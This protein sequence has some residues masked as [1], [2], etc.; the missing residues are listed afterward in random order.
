M[1]KRKL[2][3]IVFS[4]VWKHLVGAVLSA[5]IF[6][7]VSGWV[8]W[9]FALIFIACIFN[10][11]VKFYDSIYEIADRLRIETEKEM[12]EQVKKSYGIN[13]GFIR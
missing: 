2:L 9:L 8:A 7:F 13:K 6:I 11:L 10:A 3:Q 12:R 5:I 1:T 4:F